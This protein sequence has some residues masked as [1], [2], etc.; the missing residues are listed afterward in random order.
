MKVVGGKRLSDFADRHAEIRAQIEAWFWEVEEAQ[1][2]TPQDLKNRY[3]NA[4]FLAGNHVVF[5]LKGKKYR[6]LAKIGYE[7]QTV[8][9]KKLGTHS[10]YSTWVL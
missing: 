9:V 1:W 6:L 5:N 3:P 8:F 7:Q 2:K 4:S 10:E